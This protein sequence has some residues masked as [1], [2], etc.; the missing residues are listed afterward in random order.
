M[1][2]LNKLKS[3]K[4]LLNIREVAKQ[5]GINYYTLDAKLRREKQY[6]TEE[7]AAAVNIML[8]D[9]AEIINK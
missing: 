5:T 8:Q 1:T 9:I 7:Q 2:V 4:H 3:L 6:L